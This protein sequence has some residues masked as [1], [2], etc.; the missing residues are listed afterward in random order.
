ME[1]RGGGLIPCDGSEQTV[2]LNLS[3]TT[4]HVQKD[5]FIYNRPRINIPNKPP[6]HPATHSHTPVLKTVD[7]TAGTFSQSHRQLAAQLVSVVQSNT[8]HRLKG[9]EGVIDPTKTKVI[10]ACHDG[11]MKMKKTTGND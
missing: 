3:I 2:H 7:I 5:V 6:T 10:M 9:G 11:T 8:I 1:A 4:N